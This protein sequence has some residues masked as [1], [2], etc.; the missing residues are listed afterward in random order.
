MKN[1]RITI[2]AF[3]LLAAL[4]LGIG[5]A[6][7]TTQL[8]IDGSAT[9]TQEEANNEFNE[10]IYFSGVKNGSEYVASIGK[11]A[12]LGYTA[13]ITPSN[14]D[15]ATFTIE[16]MG[17]PG[18]SVTITYRVKNDSA[19]KANIT[20]NAASTT[21]THGE[22]FEVACSAESGVIVEAG[23]EADVT[24]TVTRKAGTQVDTTTTSI[25]TLVL[26][27]TSVNN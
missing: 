23:K 22:I 25:I 7:V 21:H 1:R 12:G 15:K 11:D 5:Y 16:N 18:E 8:F 9:V 20:V 6:A 2:V 4:T 26:D 10:D 17:N 27:V 13:S 19:F 14:N 24:V 3:L